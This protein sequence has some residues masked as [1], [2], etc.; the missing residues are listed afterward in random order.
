M[1]IVITMAGE[2]S[3]FKDI[4][5]TMPKYLIKANGKTLLE[6]SLLS[7]HN[8]CNEE[9]I[10]I[11]RAEHQTEEVINETCDKL[12]ISRF[13]IIDTFN[14]VTSGQAE[15]VLLAN[16][17]INENEDVLIYNIDT[18]VDPTMLRKS[19]IPDNCDGWLPS[20]KADGDNWS[21]VR[22]S[23]GSNVVEEVSEKVR[24]SEYGTIGLYYFK[25]WYSYKFAAY[26]YGDRIKEQYKEL[27]VAP[28]YKYFIDMGLNI[29]TMFFDSE[30]I[31]V[32]GTPEDIEKFAPNY[33]EENNVK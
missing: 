21:F 8:F 28:M 29:Q 6:W 11:K 17:Y 13:I 3:R 26:M 33:L 24:I 10:F 18:Y 22:C 16:D 30:S 25:H 23:N 32:L 9:F 1:K 14:G 12:G 7:L 4:G 15:T 31:H 20:F 5:L 27:Y 19:Y 2:G